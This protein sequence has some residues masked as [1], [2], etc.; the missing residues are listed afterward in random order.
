MPRRAS[1]PGAEELFRSTTATAA[2]ERAPEPALP[3]SEP[4]EDLEQPAGPTLARVAELPA[5]QPPSVAK[6]RHEEKI[7][8]YCTASELDRLERARLTLRTE[9]RIASDRGRILR[10]ALAE[11]LE[12]FEARDASSAL[13]RRLSSGA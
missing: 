12:E 6:P 13:I 11:I 5:P 8:F 10:A 9:H 4:V 1:L 3:G 2:P 7:T